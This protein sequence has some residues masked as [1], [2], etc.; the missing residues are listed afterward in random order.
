MP[1]F[2]IFGN[3]DPNRY[4]SKKIFQNRDYRQ[5]WP[6]SRYFENLHQIEIFKDFE[7]SRY[8]SKFWSKLRYF[9]NFD[10]NQDFSK[11]LTR[12]EIVGYLDQ[13]RDVLNKIEIYRRFWPNLKLSPIL[14][15]N[16]AFRK[17]CPKLR[18]SNI[19]TLIEVFG[20][21][22][23]KSRLLTILTKIAI[24]RKSWTKSGFFESLT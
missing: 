11:I 2:D 9:D 20:K 10:F 3:F 16:D 23:P 13:N 8:F 5:F 22:S 7:E 17:F 6:K 15:K 4:C 18:F 14:T 1:K 24:V 19:F 21:A 12:I